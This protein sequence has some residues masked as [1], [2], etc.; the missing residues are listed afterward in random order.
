MTGYKLLLHD[1]RSLSSQYGA[2]TYD[3]SGE[4]QEVPGHG[5][6]LGLTVPGLLRGGYGPLLAECEYTEP[7]GV[8]KDGHVVTARRVRVLRTATIDP[9]LLA[10]VA[11]RTARLVV[12]LAD[13]PTA[14]AAIEAAER[15]ERERS[16]AT[17]AAVAA[18]DAARAAAWAADAAAWA[19]RAAAW[20]ADAAAEAAERILGFL[21]EEAWP[22]APEVT[23]E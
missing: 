5:A 21:V 1:G 8:V 12:H 23:D 2:V 19:G 15:C 14:L 11:C 20:A 22:A 3:L 18:R 7:T 13:T 17:A 9:W 4:W 10:R 16:A 6:Y